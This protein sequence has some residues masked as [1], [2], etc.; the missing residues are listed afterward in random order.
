MAK[1]SFPTFATQRRQIKR[2]Q[3]T[4]YYSRTM[5]NRRRAQSMSPTT[6]PTK[7]RW[8]QFNQSGMY[9]IP[10]DAFATA[11]ASGSTMVGILQPAPA[12]A[13]GS[14]SWLTRQATAL[15]AIAARLLLHC[16]N[17]EPDRIL[18]TSTHIFKINI[19]CVVASGTIYDCNCR[20]CKIN[21]C[22]M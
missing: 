11:C 18:S 16:H 8:A 15:S 4:K 21:Y 3:V 6:W 19:V 7:C 20:S 10:A 22:L 14:E 9:R 13:Q 2:T 1:A 5:W 12:A 17:L